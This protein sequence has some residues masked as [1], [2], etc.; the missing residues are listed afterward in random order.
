MGP[1]LDTGDYKR[2]LEVFTVAL[3]EGDKTTDDYWS[4]VK[5]VAPQKTRSRR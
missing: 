3:V 1:W 4:P 2:P 5:I